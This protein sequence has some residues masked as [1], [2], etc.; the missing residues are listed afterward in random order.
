MNAA[1]AASPTSASGITMQPWMLNRQAP[2]ALMGLV[3]RTMSSDGP[4]L[5]AGELAAVPSTATILQPPTNAAALP[6]LTAE[7]QVAVLTPDTPGRPAAEINL[8]ANQLLLDNDEMTKLDLTEHSGRLD[9]VPSSGITDKIQPVQTGS[10]LRLPSGQTVDEFRIVEQIVSRIQP[11]RPQ[12]PGRIHIKLHPEELG[13]VKLN[14]VLD[15]DRVKAQLTAQSQ[16]VQE[17]LERHLPRLRD[18]LE[19]QGFKLDQLQVSVDSRG[20]G[21]RGFSQQQQQTPGQADP[22]HGSS[23]RTVSESDPTPVSRPQS[24]ASGGLSLRI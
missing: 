17:V 10:E 18:A 2:A 21:E 13:E 3:P 19:Q 1:E 15:Q 23:P 14:L 7:A 6:F 22:W 8:A 24:I 16:Q 4:A 11:S 5:A 12:E 20:A 9:A